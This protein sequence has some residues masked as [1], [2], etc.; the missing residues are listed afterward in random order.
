MPAIVEDGNDGM[1]KPN[2]SR[3]FITSTI[4]REKIRTANINKHGVRMDETMTNIVTRSVYIICICLL[5]NATGWAQSTS[6]D[7]KRTLSYNQNA[8][9]LSSSNPSIT[10][11]FD[12]VNL[13]EALK[14]IGEKARAGIY[15][16]TDLLPDKKVTLQL[17]QVPLG[18][19]LREVIA[20]TK[21]EVYTTGR[22]I[23]LREKKVESTP[24]PVEKETVIETVTG[25]VV[26]AQTQDPLPGVNV[27]IKGTSQGTATN[28]NGTFELSVSSLQDTLVFSF[29]GYQT[30]EV[31]LNGRTSVDIILSAQSIK[32]EE[33]VVVG[34][35]EQR[36]AN[37]TGSVS[38][39]EVQEV[40]EIPAANMSTLLEGRLPGVGISQTS[41]KPGAPTSLSIRAEGSLNNEPVIFVIDGFIQDKQSFDAL[42][43][44]E[45][46]DLSILKG[47]SAAIYGARAAGGVVLV[48]TKRG[49]Q[50]DVSLSYSGS[51]GFANATKVSDMLSATQHAQLRNDMLRTQFPD[52]YQ[53]QPGYFTQDELDY[54]QQHNYNWLD[55]WWKTSPTLRHALN[56]SG[57][58]DRV[59]YFAGGSYYNE[60]GNLPGT[61]Y[62]KYTLRLGLDADI[63]DAL[64][65][66]LSL[67]YNDGLDR[68][69]YDYNDRN[70]APFESTFTNLL[71]TPRWIP[72]YIGGNPVGQYQQALGNPIA[73]VQTG[74]NYR[75]TDSY[76]FT[77]N[78]ALEYTFPSVDGLEARVTYSR[79]Q[80]QGAGMQYSQDYRLYNFETTGG[81]NHILTNQVAGSYMVDND[82]KIEMSD[83]YS[84][85]Y[86][87]NA[88]LS[89]QNS[90]GKHS[91]S[92]MAGVEQAENYSF[93]RNMQRENQ[94]FPGVV[95][96]SAYSQEFDRTYSFSGNGSRLSFISRLN[97]NYDERY[98]LDATFRYDGSINFSPE[99]RWGLFPS[100]GLGWR[101]SNE[102]FFNVSFIEDLKIRA[103]A[104]RLGNDAISRRQYELVYGLADPVYLGGSDV[105]T[106]VRADNSGITLE[107]ATWEKSNSYNGGVDVTF[108]NNIS[109]S[110]DG[111]YRY[112]YDILTTRE[113]AIP[114]SVG[115]S[116]LPDENFGRVASWGY[117]VSVGY[118]GNVGNEFAYNVD[119]N[120]GFSRNK[121]LEVYQNPEVIG[122]WRDRIG[123]TEREPGY[124]STGIIRTQEQVDEILADNPDYTIF[125]QTPEP[126]MLNY[127]DVGGPDFSGPDGKIDGWDERYIDREPRMLDFNG[128]DMNL[129]ASWKGLRVNASFQ[130]SGIGQYVFYD[131]A[132]TET[133]EDGLNVPAFWTD[134]WTPENRDA[135]YPRP[136]RYGGMGQQSTFWRRDGLT[137]ELNMASASY[138]L[139]T[140]ITSRLGLSQ[141]R[142][143]FSGRNL[144]TLINPYGYKDPEVNSFNSYP[145]M[146]TFNFGLNLE[147]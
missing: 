138:S 14:K 37:L 45:I 99:E 135:V 107:G 97:Y 8:E 13:D 89:Y 124:I 2:I 71:Q 50:G 112:T 10:V 28:P 34:Y 32:G 132:A 69:P 55:S 85:N 125:G 115:I 49:A 88:E 98:L 81:N 104:A 57:G 66:S 30:K 53:T 1:G 54:F 29:I 20:G 114:T 80:N 128:L 123:T 58:T 146:R 94:L 47:P 41:G 51:A 11:D 145:V 33:L 68:R 95:E 9:V 19:A 46:D 96:Q 74:N 90:F 7:T 103:T 118:T 134:Y 110:V 121:V 52:N 64:T 35:G 130:L 129:G 12:E 93:N 133:N 65:A 102:S 73:I 70:Q 131:K 92:G 42:D 27:L 21:L 38:S 3:L 126:G 26:D 40:E 22:N 91:I 111:F 6:K 15:F 4:K 17:N 144:L 141:M 120:T 100:V 108:S 77:L 78:S 79:N 61:K 82:E 142:V 139:P 39:M 113:S 84:Q 44:S 116:E 86:Q 72:P 147:I 117:E 127:K 56:V 119:V 48:E 60:K 101:I 83:T 143:Y 109:L 140:N 5:I 36:R 136:Y 25:Q 76:G 62:K 137:L 59:R 122:T 67:S 18:Q 106:S 105:V 16:N 43:P 23:F 75:T 31:P 63:T 24:E 87:L